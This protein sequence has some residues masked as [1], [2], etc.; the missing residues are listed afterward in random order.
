MRSGIITRPTIPPISLTPVVV[1][2]V[3]INVTASYAGVPFVGAYLFE[4]SR[5][6]NGPFNAFA[7]QASPVLQDPSLTPGQT[8]FYRCRIQT[9]Y[10][11]VT[12]YSPTVFATTPA[13]TPPAGPFKWNP[14]HFGQPLDFFTAN[15]TYSAL[16]TEIAQISGLN[17]LQ[18]VMVTF[19]MASLEPIQGE[20]DVSP[21]YPKGY[22]TGA[23]LFKS[24]LDHLGGDFSK[25]FRLAAKIS[26]G[27]YTLTHPG[28]ASGSGDGSVIPTYIQNSSAYGVAGYRVGGVITNATSHGWWGGDG[29]GNT[30]AMSLH[31]PAVMA[32]LIKLAQV[33]GGYFDGHPLLEKWILEENSFFIGANGANGCPDFS[34]SAMDTQCQAY[35]TQV[36]PFWPTTDVVFENT[37]DNTVTQ[38]QA[39]HAFMNQN[40]CSPGFTDIVGQSNVVGHGQVEWGQ[41]IQVGGVPSGGTLPAKD[42]RP[43]CRSFQEAEAPDYGAFGGVRGG[44]TGADILNNANTNIQ[45]THMAWTMCPVLFTGMK[46]GT[47]WPNLGPF[48]NNPANALVNKSQ[49]PASF[50]A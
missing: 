23:A 47:D 8:A 11:G 1:D 45:P 41:T 16:Q 15:N 39:F 49:P 40:R 43:L 28:N 33:F 38:T 2:Q 4:S 48:L 7:P 27:N 29:N 25:Q 50:F 18:G 32:R 22:A 21:T 14:G 35:I 30:S 10:D 19:K 9:K 26:V 17:N 24:V 36:V 5:S 20:L 42:Y 12:P 46:A 34:S 31:R 44:F 37:F 13:N 6:V 3:Q